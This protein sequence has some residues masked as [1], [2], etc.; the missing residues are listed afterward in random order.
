MRA[1]RDRKETN[2]NL[3]FLFNKNIL[4]KWINSFKI[5][6]FS[7]KKIEKVYL[8]ETHMRGK[9]KKKPLNSFVG[10]RNAILEKGII[11]YK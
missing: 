9:K 5:T 11:V 10:K 7:I 2:V 1:L 3:S 6:L 8:V 4:L